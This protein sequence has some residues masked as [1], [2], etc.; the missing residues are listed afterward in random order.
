MP[1]F[2]GR[3]YTK[4]FGAEA[5]SGPELEQL[6]RLDCWT[7]RRE[8]R[9]PALQATTSTSHPCVCLWWCRRLP[10]TG[11]HFVPA[12][13]RFDAC[14]PPSA[15]RCAG[16]W[17][18]FGR[19]GAAAYKGPCFRAGMQ[20]SLQALPKALLSALCFHSQ[21][22]YC[23]GS[24]PVPPPG[25]EAGEE[26]SVRGGLASK[27]GSGGSSSDTPY[28]SWQVHYEVRGTDALPFSFF[29][30]AAPAAP[31]ACTACLSAAA[32]PARCPL[33][34]A[35]FPTHL[36]SSSSAPV[37]LR[38][39]RLRFSQ[40]RPAWPQG[41]G[42]GSLPRPPAHPALCTVSGCQI[43]DRLGGGVGAGVMLLDSSGAVALL[44]QLEMLHG[45]CKWVP[46]VAPCLFPCSPSV[47]VLQ[48]LLR[49]AILFHAHLPAAPAGA[50]SR[51]PQHRPGGAARQRCRWAGGRG[52]PGWWYRYGQ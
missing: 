47:P 45:G 12:C 42:G 20:G 7:A 32:H 43:V 51:G 44:A 19:A 33:P 17:C 48:A 39:A 40:V 24:S 22:Y 13:R 6:V 46:S 15:A 41:G 14:A 4:C 2:R 52:M 8:P 50:G 9:R 18:D 29:V 25:L 27:A 11:S 28:A 5:A 1:G 30:P 10:A 23:H 16:T 37:P 35:C 34:P 38:P 49:A 31:A 26:G 3:Y 36:L 21:A